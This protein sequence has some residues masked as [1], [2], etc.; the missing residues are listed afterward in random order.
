M[1]RKNREDLRKIYA[2][3][4]ALMDG[5][6]DGSMPFEN[7]LREMLDAPGT[8]DWVL[9]THVRQDMKGLRSQIMEHKV[10]TAF[11]FVGEEDDIVDMIKRAVISH[12]WD[13]CVFLA[14]KKDPELVIYSPFDEGIYGKGYRNAELWDRPR[15]T[16]DGFFAVLSRDGDCVKLE[17]AFPIKDYAD[18]NKRT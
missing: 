5:P 1:K 13:I 6:E 2:D 3:A 17:T 7:R 14:E 9:E 4:V 12:A 15:E 16:R 18:F 8:F 10:Q 11:K